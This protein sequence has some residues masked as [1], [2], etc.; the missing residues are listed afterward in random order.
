MIGV[1]RP[2][3][4]PAVLTTLGGPHIRKALKAHKRNPKRLAKNWSPDRAIYG[5]A[6]V[7]SALISAQ[8]GKCCYCESKV[9]HVCPG[10]VEHYRPKMGWRQNDNDPLQIPGYFWLSYEWSNLLYSCENCNRRYKKNLFPLSDPSKRVVAPFGDVS[11]EPTILIDPSAEDPSTK[12]SYRGDTPFAINGDLRGEETIKIVGLKNEPLRA[13]RAD[14]L[15]KLKLTFQIIGRQPQDPLHAELTALLAEASAAS[16][17]YS[18]AVRAAV[19]D[20][21][22]YV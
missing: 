17:E 12:I 6:T 7:K 19:A 13:R 8:Y 4:A 1:V 20:N 9:E 21:F 15:N 3:P 2:Q 22:K 16:S 18:A 5:H 11:Q 14:L 10:D